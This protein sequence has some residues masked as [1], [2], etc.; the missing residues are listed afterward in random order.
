MKTAVYFCKCGSITSESIALDELRIQLQ[1]TPDLATIKTVDYLCAE[2]GKQQL[3]QD[4]LEEKPDRV[5]VAACSPREYESAFMQVLQKVG[6]NP[7]YLQM[8]NIREQVAWVTPGIEQATAKAAHLIRG[9]VARVALHR[10][11]AVKQIEASP[12]VL[13]IGAGP[14]G[15]KAALTLGEAGRHVVLVEKQPVLGG[16]PV[17]FEEIF[18]NVECGPCMLEPVL[19]DLLHGKHAENIEVLTL[20]HLTSVKGYQGNFTVTIEQAPR[21]VDSEA[22][23]G[24]SMCVPVC[25]ASMENE[26]NGGLDRRNAMALPF[27][28]AL[29]NVPFLDTSICLRFQ[30]GDCQ[31]CRDACPVEGTIR[32]EDSSRTLER[33]VG[34]IVVAIGSTLYDCTQLPALGYGKIDDVYT[35]MEFER[36]LASNGPSGG[37]VTT[38]SGAAPQSVAIVHCVGSLD[39]NHKP[40]CSGICCQVAFKFNHL[41]ESKLP[42]V[43]I[44]H[45]YKELVMA[46]KEEF[47]LYDHAA[48]NPHS[49]FTRFGDMRD[50]EVTDNDGAKTVVLKK[51]DGAEIAFAAD[52]VVLCP[53]VIP[54]PDSI[55]LSQ[56]LE[57]TRD[58]LGFMEE[59][60]GRL[61]STQSKIK[62]IYLAGAC[63]GPMDLQ[64]ALTMGTAAAGYVLSELVEGRKLEIDPIVASMDAGKCSGCKICGS[65]CPYKA[66]GRSADE[67]SAEINALLCHG[68]G[69]CVAACP[70]GAIT[71]NHFTNDQILA[72]IEAILQ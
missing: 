54:A 58:K 63:Q 12:N 23:I 19:G 13:V 33:N 65:V 9:A 39:K 29:P 8:V 48:H 14:A 64:K 31:L 18:P 20:A 11:L 28:G 27:A 37:V 70:S 15:L 2:D 61:H 16:M 32:F 21:F 52:M 57:V 53:A 69:T 42:G 22:C 7:Y 36:L 49:G 24:C 4:L 71:G 62:G 72:E 60:H 34:A 41:L 26:F 43:K 45:F 17:R 67:K 38:K 30:G 59:L 46:G 5:V 55:G 3:E 6:I 47:A 51:G 50:I 68:C 66:I 10:P 40:Y 25:P 56:M 1:G 35:S 44:H